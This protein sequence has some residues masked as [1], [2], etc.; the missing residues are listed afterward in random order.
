MLNRAL[1]ENLGGKSIRLNRDWS[2]EF[3]ITE[4]VNEQAATDIDVQNQASPPS[5]RFAQVSAGPL[6]GEGDPVVVQPVSR[7]PSAVSRQPSAVSRKPQAVSR[8]P[9]QIPKRSC[10]T[11][12]TSATKHR[13]S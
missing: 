11:P 3:R 2:F 12:C 8:C 5:G 7:Q 13:D 1:R 4:I 6:Q 10:I 9:P